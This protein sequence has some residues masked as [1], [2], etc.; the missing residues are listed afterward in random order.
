MKIKLG[1]NVP[2]TKKVKHKIDQFL[3]IQKNTHQSMHIGRGERLT[4]GLGLAQAEH[5]PGMHKLWVPSH[6]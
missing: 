2:I 3:Q 1:E 6:H 5:L 4:Q